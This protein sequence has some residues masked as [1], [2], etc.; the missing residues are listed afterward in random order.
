MMNLPISRIAAYLLLPLMWVNITT[1][2][3]MW[4]VSGLAIGQILYWLIIGLAWYVASFSPYRLAA[5]GLMLSAFLL[6]IVEELS[7][8]GWSYELRVLIL[9]L[10]FALA[11]ARVYGQRP[12][13]LQR[14]LTVFFALSVPVMLLQILGASS[15]VM[16]WNTEYAHDV[17]FLTHDEIGTFK[18]IPVFPTFGVD[19]DDLRYTIGQGR[20]VGLLYSNNVLSIFL[21][22]AVVCNLVIRQTSRLKASDWIVTAAAVLAMS[23][24]VFAVAGIFYVA[25]ILF[26]MPARRPV[27]L[28]L[29]VIG[30]FGLWSYYTAFPGLFETNFSGAM[31]HTSFL[32]R[33]LDLMHAVGL[34]TTPYAIFDSDYRIE[35]VYKE[36]TSY[37]GV[38]ILLK[39]SYLKPALVVGCIAVLAYLYQLQKMRRWP[40]RIYISMFLVCVLTQFA[41]PFA[42]APSFQFLCGLALFPL[43][44]RFR[45]KR[46]EIN[47]ASHD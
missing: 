20:P 10:L 11:G 5:H 37:S 14:Q 32:T 22:V 16:G 29:L 13:L 42:A 8:F 1:A 7:G 15:F 25:S 31:I 18:D 33:S 35:S 38:A 3:N 21:A 45:V 40:T 30:L 27:G 26:G 2:E 41:V 34:E 43:L 28:K 24:A 36:E 47:R 46:D 19:I 44:S 39:S 4:S 23:K 6:R 9:A 12:Q 17:S